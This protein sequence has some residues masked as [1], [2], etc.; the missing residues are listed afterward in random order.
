V[1]TLLER[2]AGHRLAEVVNVRDVFRFFGGGSE[3]DL[4]GI[5]E[6]FE[7]LPPGGVVGGAAAMALVNDDEIEEPRRELAE[8][9][10]PILQPGDGLTEAEIDFV[11]GVDAAL[12]IEREREVDLGAVVAFDGLRLSTQLRLDL[13]KGAEV[14]HHRLVDE[15]VAVG[16][17]EDAFFA[18]RLLE[19]PDDLECGVGLAGAGRHHQQDAVLSFSDRLNGSVHSVHLVIERHLAAAVVEVVLQDNLLRLRRQ[20]LS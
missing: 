4:R 16:E 18:A 9:L 3:A 6:V 15:D 7:D 11:G 19:P 17:E 13:A 20:P 8:E 12:L 5:A 2:V 10:L 1:D 14:D